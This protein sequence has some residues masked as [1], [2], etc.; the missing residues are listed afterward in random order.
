MNNIAVGIEN[1]DVE[2][3]VRVVAGLYRDAAAGGVPEAL[4]NYASVVGAGVGITRNV[5][6]AQRYLE[7]AKRPPQTR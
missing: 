7:K 6:E 1:G 5:A 3:D 4:E 2:G